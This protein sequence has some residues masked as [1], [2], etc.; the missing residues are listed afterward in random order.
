MKRGEGETGASSLVPA[1]PSLLLH[2]DVNSGCPPPPLFPSLLLHCHVNTGCPPPPLSPSAG[3]R[4]QLNK[5]SPDDPET[6]VNTGRP[7]AP[8]PPPS[9]P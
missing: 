9:P 4:R 1:S 7:S 5:C 6:L 3:C 8:S 2:W